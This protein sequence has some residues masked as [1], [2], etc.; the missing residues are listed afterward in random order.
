MDGDG[1]A[2]AARPGTQIRAIRPRNRLMLQP[3]AHLVEALLRPAAPL[4]VGHVRPDGD[5]LG[6]IH[7]LGAAWQAARPARPAIYYKPEQISQRLAFLCGIEPTLLLRNADIVPDTVVVL[8][9]AYAE[10][11]AAPRPVGEYAASGIPLVNIDHH[12]ANTGYGQINWIVPE[13]S[14]TCELV[15]ALVRALDWPI[16]PGTASLLYAGLH[17]DT[18]GFSL[19]NTTTASLRIA[20]DLIEA[21]AD[22]AEL[23]ER[24]WRSQSPGE[25]NLTRLIYANTRVSPDGRIA[26]ST[27]RYDEILA[28]GC[29]PAD[30]DEQVS[31][32]RSWRGIRMAILFSE[33]RPGR[34]RINFRGEGGTSVLPLARAFGGGGHQLAAGAVVDGPLDQVVEEV[35]RQARAFLQ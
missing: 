1:F 12:V 27:A 33:T 13:A 21:G 4:I 34:V 5:C 18:H 19:P 7:A 15:F 2:L 25:F 22:V 9:T 32:P 23:G 11:A 29:T 3:P 35:L 6:A 14:S 17:T 20:A 24:L 28:A 10:R 31:I 30:I 16:A 8:D 26:H